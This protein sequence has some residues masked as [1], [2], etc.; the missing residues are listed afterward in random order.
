MKAKIVIGLDGSIGIVTEQGTFEAGSAKIEALLQ[1]LN[2][3]GLDIRLEKPVEQHRHD[4]P[5][6]LHAHG[7]YVHS[8]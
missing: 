1:A 5:E 6:K 4:E 8:H 7:G 2:L 3:D